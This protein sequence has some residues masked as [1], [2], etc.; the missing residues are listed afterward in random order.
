LRRTELKSGLKA[1]QTNL[2]FGYENKL[3]DGLLPHNLTSE[4]ADGV[5]PVQSEA[6]FISIY[7]LLATYYYN[8]VQPL[9]IRGT[10]ANAT[11]AELV[12]VYDLGGHLMKSN[13]K[14]DTS[15]TGLQKGVY[16][17]DGTKYA[18]R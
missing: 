16:I 14:R 17:V 18:V 9:G 10:V 7:A 13:V 15:L 1:A 4:D 6:S 12:D 5:V 11:V 8:M 2:D 3:A